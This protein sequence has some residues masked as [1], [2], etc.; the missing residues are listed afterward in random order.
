LPDQRNRSKA[1]EAAGYYEQVVAKDPLFAPAYAGL[2]AAFAAGSA[3]GFNDDHADELAGMRAA[4]EKAIQ[5]D[6]LLAE[7]HNARGM[8]YARDG[9]WT[10]AERSFRRAIELAPGDSVPY[11]DL[12]GYVLQPLGRTDES[13]RVMLTAE[14]LDPLSPWVQ[15]ILANVLLNAH[16]YEEA[17]IH[18]R[19]ATLGTECLGRARLGQGR[20]AEAIRILETGNNPRYLG[21]AYGRAGRRA[22]AE[23]LAAAV[24]ANAW[25][26]AIIFAGLGD[27]DRTLSA[28]DRV[29][30]LGAVRVGRAL[31]A[32]EFD[33]LRGD[34]RTKALRR[35]V[36]LPD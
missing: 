35:K 8:E 12:T 31:V 6:P 17:A 19:N 4:A 7:A 3:Q 30:D 23:K 10:N 28:L 15:F 34:P 1:L 2:A 27:K 26:Q 5:L 13:I 14:K 20:T 32:P 16:R 29:A 25:S 36:G 22:E 9:Q 11:S 21:Y 33:L 18:C 24:A